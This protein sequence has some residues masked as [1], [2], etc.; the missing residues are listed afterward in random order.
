[1]RTRVMVV[2]FGVAML[3]T[4]G[5]SAQAAPLT[6][7][8]S[9][10]FSDLSGSPTTVGVLD[11]GVNSI[12]GS[13]SGQSAF[14][15]LGDC[16]DYFAVQLPSGLAIV[17]WE[18]DITDFSYGGGTTTVDGAYDGFGGPGGSF[19]INGN[20]VVLSSAIFSIPGQYEAGLVSPW[21]NN[22]CTG[23]CP[24][25]PSGSFSYTVKYTVA[26]VPEPASVVLFGSGLAALC[27][28]RRRA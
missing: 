24:P 6:V 19:A 20:T 2:A 11:V 1:M 28:R 16:R 4:L 9:T 15:C 17:G 10:D 7:I 21:S 22:P 26:A 5:H 13:V 25:P 18:L 12:S 3:G 14:L 8:E 23:F 27:F